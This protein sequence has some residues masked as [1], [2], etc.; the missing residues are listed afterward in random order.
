MNT[1]WGC[2]SLKNITIPY[3]VTSIESQ[4]FFRCTNLISVTIPN[5]LTRIENYAFWECDNLTSITI[6]KS[7]TS[8][9]WWV[10]YNCNSLVANVYNDSTGLTYC[11]DNNIDYRIIGTYYESNDIQIENDTCTN[12]FE[13]TVLKVEQI[14]SGEDYDAIANYS[15]NFNLYD[16]AF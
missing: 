11:K 2:K 8:I 3:G 6:P 1:F 5:S 14:T 16:I 9:G 10:F 15:N 4:A 7:V 13:S 12:I